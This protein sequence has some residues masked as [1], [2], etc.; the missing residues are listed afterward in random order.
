VS[1]DVL[2]DSEDALLD[3]LQLR[4]GAYLK[5]AAILLFSNQAERFVP[6]SFIKIGYFITDDDLRYQDEVHG[7]LLVQVDRGTGYVF[8]AGNT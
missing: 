6:G 1:E 7:N 5:R 3:N 8:P 2:H 4:E